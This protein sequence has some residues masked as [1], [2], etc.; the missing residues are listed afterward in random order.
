MHP[1]AFLLVVSHA[2]PVEEVGEMGDCFGCDDGWER[3][4]AAVVC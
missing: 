2:G 4:F 1:G 3:Y